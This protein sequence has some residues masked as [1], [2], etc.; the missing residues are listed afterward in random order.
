MLKIQKFQTVVV[1]K[2]S[3]IAIFKIEYLFSSILTVWVH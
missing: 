2:N 1:S 3:R